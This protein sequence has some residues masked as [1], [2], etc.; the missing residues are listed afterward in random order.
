MSLR[1]LVVPLAA[2]LGVPMSN[3]MANRMNWQWDDE[4]G[5]ICVYLR[6]FTCVWLPGRGG[7]G[8]GC[9]GVHVGVS[10]GVRVG[11][12]TRMCLLVCVR[13]CGFANVYCV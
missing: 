3:V 8:R 11:V 2:H 5:D 10:V 4:T 9:V 1:E 7:G 12:R 13:A 6:V